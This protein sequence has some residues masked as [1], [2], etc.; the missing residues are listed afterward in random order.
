MSNYS[1]IE[2]S[3]ASILDRFPAQKRSIKSAYQQANYRLFGNSDFE[4]QTHPDTTLYTLE[5][6]FEVGRVPQPNFSGYYDISPF[7]EEGTRAILHRPVDEDV[8]DIILIDPDGVRVVA[9]TEAWNF[10]EGSRLQWLPQSE[11]FIYNDRSDGSIFANVVDVEGTQVDSYIFPVHAVSPTGTE[12]VSIEYPRVAVNDP[13]YGYGDAT[14]ILAPEQSGIW[15]VH[16]HSGES[17]LIVTIEELIEGAPQEPDDHYI[18]HAQYNRSGNDL[19]YLVRRRTDGGR[20]SRLHTL[21]CGMEPIIEWTTIS[22]YAWLD[23]DRMLVWGVSEQFG[24]TYHVVDVPTGN[25]AQFTGLGELP[26]GHPSVSPNGRWIVTDTYPDRRR[27]RRVTVFD[28]ERELRL[29]LGEFY[30]P[31]DYTG[32]RRCDLHPHWGPDGHTVTVDS[33]HS[34]NRRSYVL[35]LTH[36]L[37]RVDHAGTGRTVDRGDSQAPRA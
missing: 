4:W 23:D 8:C 25:V 22:H 6:W 18:N 33:T 20:R 32:T 28:R 27:R 24:P 17:S 14:E 11:R 16:P 13:E 3:I 2:R 21:S 34:G 15:R 36:L 1:P 31:L 5:N 7:N 30:S 19:A 26:D 35:D 10:Q 37:R 9:E 12:Y 29:P